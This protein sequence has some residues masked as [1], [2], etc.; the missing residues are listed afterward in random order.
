MCLYEGG[1]A[2]KCVRKITVFLIAAVLIL[3]LA[4]CGGGQ[5][6]INERAGYYRATSVVENG[7]KAH[8]S[9]M[10]EKRDFVPV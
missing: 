10:L 1:V 9:S 2:E 7:D 6:A 5:K 4:G 8:I 3:S